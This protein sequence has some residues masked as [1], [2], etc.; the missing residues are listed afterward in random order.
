MDFKSIFM[1]RRGAEQEYERCKVLLSKHVMQAEDEEEAAEVALD[2]LQ[3]AF[4]EWFDAIARLEKAMWT[5]DDC[6]CDN[7]TIDYIGNCFHEE[8]ITEYKQRM[9]N[10]IYR[11]NQEAKSAANK[12]LSFADYF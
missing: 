1:L 9:E 12:P 8:V 10:P 3:D 2:V 4:E 11:E 5:C 6:N 7:K